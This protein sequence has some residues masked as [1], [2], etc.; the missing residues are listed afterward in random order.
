MAN[1]QP[2]SR[3][4]VENAVHTFVVASEKV[5]QA[6]ELLKA[7]IEEEKQA[8]ERT[9]EKIE[10]LLELNSERTASITEKINEM[11]EN[12]KLIEKLENFVK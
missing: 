6:N 11:E 4:L 8:I 9:E 12:A 7:S 5:G 1:K 10:S 3:K 2:K